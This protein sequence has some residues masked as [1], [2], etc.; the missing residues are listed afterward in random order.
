MDSPTCQPEI[1]SA[2]GI[3]F[4]WPETNGGAVSTFVCPGNEQFTVRRRC[5]PGG[6]WEA[7]DNTSCGVLMAVF[8]DISTSSQNVSDS[9]L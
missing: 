7:F 1:V 5:I 4:T 8:R 6:R 9:A 3:D 2:N